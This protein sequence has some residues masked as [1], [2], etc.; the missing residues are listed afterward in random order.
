MLAKF[1]A[2]ILLTLTLVFSHA[3]ISYALSCV[4]DPEKFDFTDDSAQLF[5]SGTE[6]QV[7]K[8]YGVL[9]EVVKDPSQYGR[10]TIF[11]ATNKYENIT[12]SYCQADKCNGM[13]ILKGLQDCSHNGRNASD[14]C[15]PLAI[16]YK[17]NLYCLLQPS[18]ENYT[19]KKEFSTLDPFK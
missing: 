15:F 6:D 13:D 19:N 2:R 16:V 12:S 5:H 4:T 9:R 11:Y 8:S 17:G 7:R 18:L 3:E 10:T 1:S 14:A